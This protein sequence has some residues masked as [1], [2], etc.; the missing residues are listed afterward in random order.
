MSKHKRYTM[1]L[2]FINVIAWANAF[3]AIMIVIFADKEVIERVHWWPL[4]ISLFCICFRHHFQ[5]LIVEN[6]RKHWQTY[7][8]TSNGE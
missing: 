1:F 4:V 6:K 2:F 7:D 3:I 8:D 5:H